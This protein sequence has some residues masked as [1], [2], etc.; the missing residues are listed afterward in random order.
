MEG[1]LDAALAAIKPDQ[2]R[3]R[4]DTQ[5]GVVNLGGGRR[6]SRQM[7][8]CIAASIVALA[9][10][11]ATG[12]V[13][14]ADAKLFPNPDL[15]DRLA[16]GAAPQTVVLAGGCFWGVQAVYQHVKGVARATSGYAGGSAASAHYETVSGGRTGH[17]ESVEVVYDPA[18][19]TFGQLLKIFFSVVH[20]PTELNR[21]GPDE[22][23]QYRSAIFCTSD[24]QRRLAA[25]YIAQLDREGVYRRRIVTQVAALEA[26]YR[27]EEYHQNYAERHP[28]EPYI[29]FNDRPKV[30]ALRK[31]YPAMYVAH[32]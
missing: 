29:M 15:D 9:A 31:I 32:R 30:D 13:R 27:A 21:Q 22:G 24:S 17:A 14:G 8:L 16:D 18:Q 20:D 23:P 19:V 10:T 6:L 7:K 4:S 28:S 12:A 2:P 11:A 3:P 26:F 25:A 5:G 1:A